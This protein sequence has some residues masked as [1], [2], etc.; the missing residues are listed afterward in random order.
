M[1]VVVSGSGTITADGKE[2]KV[3][4][5]GTVD[6][7]DTEDAQAGI[8]DIEVSPGLSLYSFTFG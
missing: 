2:F 3:A 1:Q 8:L 7:L 4:A 5:D 6:L